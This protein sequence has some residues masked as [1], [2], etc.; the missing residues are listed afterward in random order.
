M[1]VAFSLGKIDPL[2]ERFS[3]I[4]S[5]SR[6]FP[7]GIY[8]IFPSCRT[9]IFCK[10]SSLNLLLLHISVT[11]ILQKDAFLLLELNIMH[12]LIV[13]SDESSHTLTKICVL[14]V[15][16]LHSVSADGFYNS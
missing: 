3:I 8:R 10:V 16:E 13:C 5:R 9:C 7:P 6:Q 15:V 1:G 11:N 4:F 12:L 14:A 2:T